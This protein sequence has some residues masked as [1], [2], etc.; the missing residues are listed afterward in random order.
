M[1]GI[2]R[3]PYSAIPSMGGMHGYRVKSDL[4]KV[5]FTLERFRANLAH[6]RQS[7]SKC[8]VAFHIKQLETFNLFRFC[9]A[10]ERVNSHLVKDEFTPNRE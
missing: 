4:I 2:S 10:A 7:R 6:V 8:V 5:E 1:K 3:R 9:S